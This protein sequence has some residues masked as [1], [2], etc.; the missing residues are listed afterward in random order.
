MKLKV[1][2]ADES[3][4]YWRLVIATFSYKNFQLLPQPGLEPYIQHHSN[5]SLDYLDS[6]PCPL[7]R[8]QLLASKNTVNTLPHTQLQLFSNS[9]KHG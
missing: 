7:D 1:K 6:Y 9:S 8:W 2:L 5:E 4:F 3:P